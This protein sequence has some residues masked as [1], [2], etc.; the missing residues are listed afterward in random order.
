[1]LRAMGPVVVVID[2]ADAALGNREGGGD[3]GTSSRVF[4]MIA[5]QMGDTRYRGKLL[6]MLLTSRPDLLPIDLKRQGRAEVHLPLFSPSDDDEIEFM[7]KVM[8]RKNK[9]SLADGACRRASPAEASP[10]PTSRASCS[11][12]SGTALTQGRDGLTRERSRSSLE[13]FHPVGAGAG[14]RESKSWR[15]CSSARR[16]RSC[17][18]EWRSTRRQAGRAG[19]A[20]GTNGRD[21][22][23]DRAMTKA[24]NSPEA[25]IM[26]TKKDGKGKRSHPLAGRK[27]RGTPD[28]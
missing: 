9:A 24:T 22:P 11:R 28:R 20:P 17:R 8:A 23:D 14:K 13:R 16:C 21:P 27:N 7:I 4:S 1:M 2:E 5:S 19:R 6:W 10:G 26:S 15:P 3:S 25:A 18:T 12:P